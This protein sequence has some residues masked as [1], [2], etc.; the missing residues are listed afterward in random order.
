MLLSTCFLR[1]SC[2]QGWIHFS[3]L[4]SFA[5]PLQLIPSK[6]TQTVAPTG[7]VRIS[8]R[9][10]PREQQEAEAAQQQEREMEIQREHVRVQALEKAT[11]AERDDYDYGL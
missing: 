3:T 8:Q 7:L 6:Q 10:Q 9:R 5:G 11:A 1:S 4:S 2:L